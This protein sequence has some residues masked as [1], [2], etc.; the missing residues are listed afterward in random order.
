MINW[1]PLMTVVQ[2]NQVQGADWSFVL[3]RGMKFEAQRIK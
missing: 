1:G 3:F 2:C